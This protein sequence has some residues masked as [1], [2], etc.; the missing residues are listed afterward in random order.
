VTIFFAQY[1]AV[2]LPES[3][4]FGKS[5]GAY[6]NCWLKA[7]SQEEAAQLA[8]AFIQE[9]GWKVVSVEAECREVP[10]SLYSEDDDDREHYDQAMID[11]ECYVL[12]QWPIDAQESDDVH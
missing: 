11:G 1:E 12:H 3:E 9:R 7:Q 6:I 2:P 8:S 5:G 10:H 4:D